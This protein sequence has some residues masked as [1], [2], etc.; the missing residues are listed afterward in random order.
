M[1]SALIAPIAGIA[2]SV[3]GGIFGSSA[4]RQ[5][6]TQY[7]NAENGVV[8]ATQSGQ[9]N[10]QNQL[11]ANNT[12][13]NQAGTNVTSAAGTANSNLQGTLG[14]IQSNLSPY[15]QGGAQGANQLAAYAGSNPQ[16]DFN[17]QNYLNSP[18]Y[19]FQLQGGSEAIQ[20]NLAA[21]GIGSSS[22]ALQG[23]TNYGQGLASTYYNQ[24]FNNAQSQ[25]QTNQNTTLANLQALTGTGLS[26]N[27]QYNNAATGIAGLQSANTTGAAGTNA[28]LQT[29]LAGQGLQGNEYGAGFGLQGA[30]TAG[31]FAVGQGS[32]QAAGTMAVGN[33]ISGALTGAGGLAG[34]LN[35][36]GGFGGG[37]INSGPGG[38]EW[39]GGYAGG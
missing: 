16:F 37:G 23:L 5:L 18:A 3:V 33:A 19:Q 38:D 21:Q 11:A 8:Q 30:T 35:S 29:T 9:T 32:A 28:N 14:G 17:L 36:M 2:S 34:G 7:N 31:N 20:N 1:A 4:A 10:L 26:A 6:A 15:M 27:Q 24:A 39:S 13:I 25:F 22:N 12:A